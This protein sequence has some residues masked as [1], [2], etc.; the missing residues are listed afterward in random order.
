MHLLAPRTLAALIA[1]SL[2]MVG[3]A[4]LLK[5]EAPQASPTPAPSPVPTVTP[6]PILPLPGK[7]DDTLVFNS[8]SPEIV[9]EPGIL[10]STLPAPTEADR[11]VHLNQPFA[12][13]FQVFSHHIAKDAN[14]GDRLLT[15]GLLAHNPGDRA[16]RL[17]L[18]K[19]ASYLSQPDALFVPL[20]PIIDD[21][22]G[23]V[24][25][26]PGDRVAT[27]WLNGR[28]P[29][30]PRT[31]WLPAKSSVLVYNL[32]VPTDVAILP[33]INGRTTQ[34]EFV[35]DGL[36]HLAEVAAFAEKGPQGFTMPTQ[37]DYERVLADRRLAG[38]RDLAPTAYD[39]TQ[40]V[41]KGRFV[42]GRVA[43]VSHGAYWLGDLLAPMPGESIGY[44]I[45]TALL[46]RLGTDQV[47]SAPMLRRYADTAYHAHGNYGV[48]YRLSVPLANKTDQPRRFTFT[49]SS[50]AKVEGQLLEAKLT[51]LNPP[52]RPVMFRGPVELSWTARNG[53][54]QTRRTHV[55]VQHGQQMPPFATVEVP[56]YATYDATITLLY[57]ADATPP[58]LLTIGN[59]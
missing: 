51:Y 12:G 48:T 34:I 24:Y 39:P 5:R 1:L 43:G 50:P 33:P 19:G 21:P 13:T 36:I 23:K 17:E 6:L 15:L 56:P 31:F 18:V 58:Q 53:Q 11:D 42:F 35:S 32:A 27:D 26:G 2:P 3:C 7:L 22:T 55:V 37:A 49:L 40:P 25:A 9:Q 38:P 47:Q 59:P 8:N 29:I 16:V 41:P 20:A 28:S 45:A 30:S 54:K 10:L 57:P 44:P 14:P 4:A 52:N 46:N